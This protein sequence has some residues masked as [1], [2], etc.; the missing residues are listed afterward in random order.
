LLNA[1][2]ILIFEQSSLSPPSTEQRR[3]QQNSS[4]KARRPRQQQQ[5][6]PTREPPTK[7]KI[8]R[9]AAIRER[10]RLQI[11][12]EQK[13]MKIKQSN[14]NKNVTTNN[15]G[16]NEIERL[17]ISL[18][19]PNISRTTKVGLKKQLAKLKAVQI[20]KLRKREQ[21]QR[22]AQRRADADKKRSDEAAG[23]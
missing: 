19:D 16:R 6:R 3:L 2:A 10:R 15:G 18:N 21:G 7:P 23:K 5:Q 13:K 1:F 4:N 20:R 14:K 8:D 12:E 17:E 22:E 11:E 9:G